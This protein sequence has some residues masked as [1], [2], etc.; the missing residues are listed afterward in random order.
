[1]THKYTGFLV[2]NPTHKTKKHVAQ[3]TWKNVA[4]IQVKDDSCDYYAWFIKK[5]FGLE[6]IKPLRGTHVTIIN[7]RNTEV[8]NFDLIASLYNGKP[9]EFEIDVNSIQT[10]GEHWWL[11]V[12]CEKAKD[13]REEAGGLRDPHMS[14]HLTIGYATGLR[15]EHSK[16]ISGLLRKTYFQY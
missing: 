5:R 8:P 2:F 13:I 6:L 11:K 3:S 10:N 15:L 9:I 4:F 16:Y 7:D 14:L 12:Y 1:M